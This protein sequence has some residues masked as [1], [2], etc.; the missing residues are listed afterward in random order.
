MR[1]I[2]LLTALALGC[3]GCARGP[4]AALDSTATGSGSA[5]VG[6]QAIAGLG[7]NADLPRAALSRQ[8]GASFGS[9]ADR[10]NLVGYPAKAVVRHDGAYTWHR[11]D[12]SEMHA[13]HAIPSG[14]LRVTAPSGEAL[15][16][17]YERHVE[18]PSGDWTWVGRLKNGAQSDEVVLTFGDRAA[19]GTIAQSGGKAPLM[20]T[21]RDG[22]AW[23][24]ETD[25]TKI[26]AIDNP[27]TRPKRPDFMIPPTSAAAGADQASGPEMASAGS[28]PVTTA[29]AG[30]T[31][32]VVL[33]YT[34]GFAADLGGT[35]QAVTR[36]NNLVEIANQA[37]ANS[38][39]DARVRLV[40]TLQVNFPD[41]TDNG[42]ALEKLTGYKSGTGDVPPD[43]AF[44][45]L[46]A[47]RDQYG[48]D[49]VSLVRKFNTPENDGCGI[50]W[51][52]G[53]GQSGIDSGDARFGYSVVSDGQDVGSDGRNYF[54]RNETL[55]HE[56]GHNMGSQHD[57]ATAT[58]NGVL[59][60]G[61]YPYSFGYKTAAGSGNF[62]TVMAYGDSG[63]TSY[64]IFSNPRTTFCGGFAC[65]I[66]DNSDNARSLAQ[67]MPIV[68][69]FRATVVAGAPVK[70]DVDGNGYSDVA[71]ARSGEWA[72]Y[73]YSGQG[74]VASSYG[75]ASVGGG[76]LVATARLNDDA[77]ADLVFDS[78]NSIE[79][80]I[81]NGGTYMKRTSGYYGDGWKFFGT[82][83]VDGNGLDE[84]IF[85]QY[86]YVAFWFLSNGVV[87]NGI[88][89]GNVG[90]GYTL[91][92]IG[93]FDSNKAA[94]LLW[95]NGSHAL[96]WI[97]SGT[98]NY[99]QRTIGY[100]GDGWK[101][102]GMSDLNADGREDVIFNRGTELTYWG[103]SDGSIVTGA[104]LGSA[105]AGFTLRRAAD[106]NGDG[107]T[108][109]LWSN[110]SQLKRWSFGA[111]VQ[112]QESIIGYYGGGDGWSPLK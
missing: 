21:I 33:G 101:I 54:C 10:G 57:R 11:A 40:H 47:A 12:I 31:V 46:R 42:D 25:R 27:A 79:V 28:Q 20:L 44:S 51:L 92:A 16:F 97:H 1:K 15:E 84:I 5:A 67:T 83:D 112:R 23:L 90:P 85:T 68:A 102:Y 94:D 19:F 7:G 89:K 73:T 98:Y 29:A 48:A 6:A 66:A 96:A 59:K 71:F 22:V 100:Y 53:G 111:S 18:H 80:W 4:D 13:V 24:V 107:V 82:A 38:Q 81:S 49:L 76:K 55:A 109:Y 8:A 56:L 39:L 43:P 75:G 37:Y 87:A 78:G 50:A 70:D 30:T 9:L 65:G 63:Q 41:N 62:Y 45:A 108:D 35:S 93:N 3:A 105:G 77:M 17:S 32:D 91:A 58:D 34:S 103:L 69:T 88:Y 26:A 2:L 99:S 74:F 60:Y 64:R 110:G 86:D 104:Y 36:L 61:V 14:T 95:T 106:Y 72:Y 52:I